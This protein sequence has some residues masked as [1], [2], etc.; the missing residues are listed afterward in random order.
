MQILKGIAAS[1]GIA[2]GPAYVV[3]PDSS[4]VEKKKIPAIAVAWEVRRYQMALQRT[5][6]DLNRGEVRVLE[7]FGQNYAQ[8]MEA[9]KLILSDPMLKDGVIK[10]IEAEHISAESALFATVQ[11]ITANFENIKDEFF[12]ERKFDVADVSKRLFENLT[13][14]KQNKFSDIKERSV[15]I[16]HSLFPSDTIHLKSKKVLGF[17]TDIGGKTSHT[18]ILA[19]SMQMP[20]VVGLSNAAAQISTGDMII[21]DGQSGLLIIRPDADTLALYKKQKGE[22]AAVE[23]SLKDIS[24]LP[25][26]TKDGHKTLLYINYDP[27]RDMKEWDSFNSEGMGLL[28]TEYLYMDRTLPPSEDEQFSTYKKAAQ[29]FGPRPITIRLADLGGDKAT[30]L[31]L[32]RKDDE[33]NPFM[34]C[35]GIRLFLKYPELMLTQMRAIIRTAAIAEGQVNLMVPMISDVEEVIEVKK[36][37]SSTLAEMSGKGIAPKL[38]IRLCVMIEVPSAALTMDGILPEV[39]F[40][41]IGTNDL[42]QYLLAVDR[43]NQEVADLYDPYHPAVLRTINFIIQAAHK[44]GKQVSICGEMASDPEMIPFLIGLGVDILSITP[45]MFLRIKNTLRNLNFR[46]C[47]NLAQAAIL[48]TSSQEIKKLKEHYTTDEDDS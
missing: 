46:D 45:R 5:L 38:P 48:L 17:A 19:Q 13:D 42:I 33:D 28:R 10:K 9:H 27:R 24:S 35:R 44:K 4:V 43:V 7:L 21:L 22:F 25:N 3:K 32:A 8:L 2:I 41:S 40:I 23:K 30:D 29:R 39:D 31:G 18:A 11:E 6:D 20:A 26:I 36:A 34:G 12:R 1:P 37:F 14:K 16:A 15:V 47:S